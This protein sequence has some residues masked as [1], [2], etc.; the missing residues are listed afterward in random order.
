MDK[1]A[2]LLYSQCLNLPI[3]S[4]EQSFITFPRRGTSGTTTYG[5][6]TT[7][8][9]EDLCRLATDLLSDYPKHPISWS[10]AALY[11]DIKGDKDKAMLFIDKVIL[12]LIINYLF[13]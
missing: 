7:G 2:V 12:I 1:Y 5:V 4:N 9:R 3:S 8:Y 13:I 10:C 6:D 11:T